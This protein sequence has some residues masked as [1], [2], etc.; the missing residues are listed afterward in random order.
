MKERDR[1]KRK[2]N[3]SGETEEIKTFPLY[4]YLLQGQKVLPNCKP[5]SVGH[6]SDAIYTTP[7]PHPTT[8][9]FWLKQEPYLELC[10]YLQDLFWC[11]NIKYLLNIHIIWTC[12]VEIH[13]D[14][15]R[16]LSKWPRL[17][18]FIVKPQGCQGLFAGILPQIY[19]CNAGLFVG[20][21]KLKS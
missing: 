13:Q 4:P 18:V 21:C 8:P 1:R 2:M 15:A 10:V 5:I 14:G 19:P 9:T 20:L 17:F 16:N 6:P 7:L 12:A 3:E 11:K